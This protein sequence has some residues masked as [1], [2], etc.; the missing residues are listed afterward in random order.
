MPTTDRPD[1]PGAQ[2]WV[3]P[4]ADVDALRAAAPGC[5]GC[6]LWA[7]ATQVVVSTGAETARVM[8]VG[9]QPGDAE[10]REGAPFVGP[11][12]KLLARAVEEAGLDLRETYLTNAVKHFRFTPRGKRRIHQTP[13]LAHISACRPWLEAELRAVDPEIVV[14]LG[15]TAARSVM[16]PGVKVTQQRG[17]VVV[18]EAPD[19]GERR[20]VPTVHP[21][22]VLRVPGADRQAA[23]EALVADLRVVARLLG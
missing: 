10:D 19:G 18:R 8:L 14:P 5:R 4:D 12:G 2:Q 7:P 11:A 9:E 22:S 1:R 6:E 3:P 16:G 13:D 15:A 23:Y 20:F 21:S 17:Q